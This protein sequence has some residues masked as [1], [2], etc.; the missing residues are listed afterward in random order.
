MPMNVPPEV[1]WYRRDGCYLKGI[2]HFMLSVGGERGH[3]QVLFHI[4]KYNSTSAY[5]EIT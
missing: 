2:I 3:C 1:T 5:Y 4:K